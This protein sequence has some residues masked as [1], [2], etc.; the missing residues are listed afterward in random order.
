M[1]LKALGMSKVLTVIG[2]SL[3]QVT[4]DSANLA[5]IRCFKTDDHCSLCRHNQLCTE[6]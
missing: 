1:T 2:P 3:T 6:D 5:L 4:L